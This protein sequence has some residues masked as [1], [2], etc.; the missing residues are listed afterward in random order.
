MKTG[1]EKKRNRKSAVITTVV[2]VLLLFVLYFLVAWKEPFPP[3]PEYGIEI[4]FGQEETGR[5][6]VASTLSEP[7]ETELNS[8]PE[9]EEQTVPETLETV[10]EA[11]IEEETVDVESPVESSVAQEIVAQDAS[12]SSITSEELPIDPQEEF[13][14]VSSDEVPEELEKEDQ[15]TIEEVESADIESQGEDDAPGLAGDPEVAIDQRA[16]YGNVTGQEGASL[17]LT[18]W[19]WDFKPT[20]YDDSQETG[21]I[22][23]KVTIDDDGYLIKIVTELSTV[24]PTVEKYYRQAVERLTFSKTS[25]Y[26]PAATSVGSITFI[27]KTR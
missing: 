17:Q 19:V 3:I 11:S 18:G 20:P 25:T 16:L 4:S 9:I 12:E 10:S 21:K 1:D 7:Q 22:V 13:V 5:P 8:E 26:K 15:P 2:Q 23:Y 14:E 24:S 6:S 27:I